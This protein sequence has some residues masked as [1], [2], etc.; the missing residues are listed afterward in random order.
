MNFNCTWT[1]GDY[2]QV[3]SW[4]MDWCGLMWID[5]D[6]WIM[7]GLIWFRWSSII[8]IIMYRSSFIHHSLFICSSLVFIHHPSL[9]FTTHSHAC[10]STNPTRA[11]TFVFS[12]TSYEY[13]Y[14]HH[15]LLLKFRRQ[16]ISSI[17]I[18]SNFWDDTL[19]VSKK[20]YGIVRALNIHFGTSSLKFLIRWGLR[21]IHLLYFVQCQ[22]LK[23]CCV[24][25]HRGHHSHDHSTLF[26]RRRIPRA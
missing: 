21:S 26:Y 12:H 11:F 6:W 24:K 10:K 8:S 7:D 25:Y 9:F 18:R 23:F 15:H 14:H 5:V 1:Y 2:P 19:L 17:P 3:K 4:L 20:M 16:L 22:F 13:K